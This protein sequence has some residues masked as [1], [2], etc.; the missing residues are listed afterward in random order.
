M[1][2]FFNVILPIMLVFATGFILQRIRVLDVKSV[3]AVCLYILSPALVFISLYDAEFNNGYVVILVYTF[4]LFG[5]MVLL[6]KILARIFKWS[7]NIESAS[8]L[9]TGFMNSG[10]YGLPVVLFA[11]GPEAL[12]Y[13]V[14]IM[15]IQGLQNNFFGVYY[16][17]RSTSGM[18]QALMNVMKMPTTYAMFIAFIFQF[19]DVSI[20]ISMYDTLSMVGDAAIPVMMIMLG[21]QLGSMT[22]IKLNWQVIT[23]AVVLKMIGAPLIAFIFITLS[24]V[25]PLIG[26]ILLIISAMPT[27]ATTTMYAIE[28]DTEPELVSS[29]TFIATLI[30][31]VSV[32]VLLNI[33]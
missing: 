20:P 19:L 10:N 23:S 13:A 21:M 12:P 6:N 31:I 29:I 24:N 7:Q 25:D 1:S 16:A 5:I 3:S 2:L 11:L 32:T 9:A 14:F 22:G 15:V 33:M 8:I 27:A 18:K 26:A 4:L 30:S 28:F 17:S